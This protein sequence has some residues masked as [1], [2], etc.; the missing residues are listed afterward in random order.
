MW[1]VR[2]TRKSSED[3]VT[4]NDWPPLSTGVQQ[5]NT[6]INTELGLFL[7]DQL[8]CPRQLPCLQPN[9]L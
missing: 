4:I 6:L 3:Y 1:D 9:V 2:K 8:H 5:N 7:P